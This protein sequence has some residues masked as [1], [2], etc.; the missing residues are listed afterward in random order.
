MVLLGRVRLIR[1]DGQRHIQL[2]HC[3]LHLFRHQGIAV[4]RHRHGDGR[5]GQQPLGVPRNGPLLVGGETL[6]RLRVD[7]FRLLVGRQQRAGIALGIRAVQSVDIQQ[8]RTALF[9]C[10]VIS[11]YIVCQLGYQRPAVV[12]IL[13]VDIPAEAAV[14]ETGKE[15]RGIEGP[16]AP[17]Q[18]VEDAAQPCE[19][20]DGCRTRALWQG[21]DQVIR[22]YLDNATLAQLM[23]EEKDEMN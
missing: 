16:L 17:V 19:M 20:A 2:P 3:L 9:N 5:A 21:L 18:C 14:R 11:L 10:Q 22:D 1:R 15:G 23:V 12:A 6:P 4:G 8:Q 13:T 7:G